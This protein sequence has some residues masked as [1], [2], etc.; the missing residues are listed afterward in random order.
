MSRD[1]GLD[2][3]LL[4]GV[5]QDSEGE[6]NRVGLVA[7]SVLLD[8]DVDVVGWVAKLEVQ[9]FV[10]PGFRGLPCQQMSHNNLKIMGKLVEIEPVEY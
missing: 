6:V 3:L 5:V 7:D 2:D 4:R 10:H 9:D 8:L 1:D